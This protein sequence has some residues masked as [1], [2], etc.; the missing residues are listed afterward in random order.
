M[1]YIKGEA[2]DEASPWVLLEKDFIIGQYYKRGWEDLLD[3]TRS[4]EGD[5][6]CFRHIDN[7][8][9]IN[10]KEYKHR[11]TPL[12]ECHEITENIDEQCFWCAERQWAKQEAKE[13]LYG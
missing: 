3:I 6:D 13:K 12:S 5:I 7:N 2:Y 8:P 9:F 1:Q 10:Y 4:C 11:E